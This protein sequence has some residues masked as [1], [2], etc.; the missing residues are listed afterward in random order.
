M[1]SF[2]PPYRRTRRQRISG[3]AVGILLM[4]AGILLYSI[5]DALGKWLVGTYSVGTVLLFR[6][7]AALMLLLP[8]IHRDGG[9]AGLRRAPRP[10]LQ[11]LRACITTIEIGFFYGSVRYLPLADVM[12]FYLSAPIFV[13]AMS[14]IIL[15]EPIDRERWIAVL[16][17]FVGVLIVLRPSPATFSWPALIAMTGSFLFSILMIVTR[18]LRGTSDSSLLAFTVGGALVAG[19]VLAPIGWVTPTPKDLALLSLL[20]V[21]ALVA[22]LFVN[23]SLKLAPASVVV[24]YQYTMLLWAV[25]FGYLFFGDRPDATVLVGAAI[26]IASGLYIFY[27]ERRQP[28]DSTLA[29]EVGSTL[30]AQP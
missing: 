27:R 16:V 4:L 5:N 2:S 14:A 6:S 20:G 3:R 8:F 9:I 19:L 11:W 29:S 12:T 30:D 7:F 17:G 10:G 22:S 24:P 26:V 13:A 25:L 21:V 15:K 18:Q 1:T 23:R 28:A